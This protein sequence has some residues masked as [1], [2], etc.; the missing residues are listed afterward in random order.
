MRIACKTVEV[1]PQYEP[2]RARQALDHLATHEVIEMRRDGA[3]AEPYE[4][5]LVVRDA[6]AAHD[7]R[8]I[9]PELTESRRTG[10]PIE[11]FAELRSRRCE[12][13]TAGDLRGAGELIRAGALEPR[14][15]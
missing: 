8:A 9:T 2:D 15:Q 14:A 1:R 6:S 13:V 5:E 11:S 10:D 4:S 12:H 3:S 7:H